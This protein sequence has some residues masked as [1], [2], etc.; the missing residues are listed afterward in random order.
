MTKETSLN[1]VGLQCSERK[2][3]EI[4]FTKVLQ[5][6]KI[7]TFEVSEE[8]SK[9]IFGIKN[10]VAIDVYDNGKTKFEVFITEKMK[11][12][13]YEHVCIEVDN[14][15]EFIDCCKK[16]GIEPLLVRKEGKDLLFVRDFSDNLY[17]V[18]ERQ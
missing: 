2:K 9:A 17:E 13:C 12:S 14:K 4:F 8:L 16:Y 11:D 18:K 1:H 6:P 3:A 10:S 15:E 7:R 5:I